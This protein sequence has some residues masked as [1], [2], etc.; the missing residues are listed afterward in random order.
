MLK[1]QQVM[2]DPDKEKRALCRA[3]NGLE[4]GSGEGI[5]YW[6]DE[7]K[8]FNLEEELIRLYKDYIRFKVYIKIMERLWKDYINNKI[9][10]NSYI[11]LTY[12]NKL[13]GRVP[14]QETPFLYKNCINNLYLYL[15][16]RISLY[17]AY[18]K[19]LLFHPWVFEKP[20]L[21]KQSLYKKNG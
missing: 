6:L 4:K 20:Y 21:F 11:N 13:F 10:I 3:G 2:I 1:N 19:S 14:I 9:L 12:L 18:I 17:K 7:L 16:F 8:K 15:Y 5:R